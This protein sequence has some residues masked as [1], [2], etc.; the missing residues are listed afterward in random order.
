[1]DLSFFNVKDGFTEALL[2]RDS[3][4]SGSG[5]RACLPDFEPVVWFLVCLSGHAKTSRL[6]RLYTVLQMKYNVSLTSRSWSARK[7]G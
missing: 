1:M 5:Y 3:S 4:L 2:F 7:T 6:E